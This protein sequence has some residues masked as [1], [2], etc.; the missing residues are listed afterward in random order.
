MT[1]GTI[2]SSTV[3]RTRLAPPTRFAPS[4]RIIRRTAT[5]GR[6]TTST[7]TSSSSRGNSPPGRRGFKPSGVLAAPFPGRRLFSLERLFFSGNDPFPAQPLR[8]IVL[9]LAPQALF[10][11]T[12]AHD[13]G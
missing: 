11:Q 1:V 7:A 2:R 6:P 8:R 9:T 5:Q 10:K 12:V 3:P 13:R 4:P